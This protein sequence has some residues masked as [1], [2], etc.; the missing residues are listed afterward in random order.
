MKTV[1]IHQPHYLIW[2]GLLDKIAKSDLFVLLDNVQYKKRYFQNRAYYSTHTGTKRLSLPVKSKGTQCK[3]IKIKD[4]LI[5]DDRALKKHFTTLRHRYGKTPGWFLI[6]DQLHDIYSTKHTNLVDIN[7][8]LLDLTLKSYK[9]ET[10]IINASELNTSGNKSELILSILKDVQASTYLSG[11]GARSYMKHK[12]FNDEDIIINY[13]E[14]NHPI[15][16]QD[17]EGE[18]SKSCFALEW[19][20][21]DPEVSVNYFSN[22]QLIVS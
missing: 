12:I 10:P 18:F 20:F 16:N 14:F 22:S 3:K 9:I 13:Q 15:Y 19:F 6:K 8:Q 7:R 1:S 11:N 5:S 21:I 2:L 17:H 4:I